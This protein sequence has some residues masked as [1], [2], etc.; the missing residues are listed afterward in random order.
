MPAD[1]LASFN[2]IAFYLDIAGMPCLRVHALLR[3]ETIAD[4]R[5]QTCSPKKASEIS[6]VDL[7]A[8]DLGRNRR[9]CRSMDLAPP[10]CSGYHSHRLPSSYQC[11]SRNSIR[12]PRRGARTTSPIDFHPLTALVAS[13][14]G[15]VLRSTNL[16]SRQREK[17]IW[18]S[19]RTP[20]ERT[21]SISCKGRWKEG[22]VCFRCIDN[23]SL[24]RRVCEAADISAIAHGKRQWSGKGRVRTIEGDGGDGGSSRCKRPN[25]I[26]AD[27]SSDDATGSL[28]LCSSSDDG[29]GLTS[30]PHQRD[31]PF[32]PPRRSARAGIRSA[33]PCRRWTRA[34]MKMCCTGCRRAWRRRLARRDEAQSVR[35]RGGQLE[36][37]FRR[38]RRKVGRS[39][40]VTSK[41]RRMMVVA[42]PRRPRRPGESIDCLV[43]S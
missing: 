17:L 22:Y 15:M 35:G 16:A 13:A 38:L 2:A 39:R 33:G 23:H 31:E 1:S 37:A 28:T 30:Q 5:Y 25:P 32:A 8:L 12:H 42:V 9:K 43:S 26:P 7:H 20:M 18:M 10:L 6:A 14:L 41:T 19:E 11:R 4:T 24:D 34:R 21:W 27:R 3:S 36:Q 29:D 40:A